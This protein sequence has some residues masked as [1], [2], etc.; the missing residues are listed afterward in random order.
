[1]HH[2]KGG[3]KLYGDSPYT[4]TRCQ[5]KNDKGYRLF[6]GGFGSS[7]LDVFGYNY[8]FPGYRDV[9]IRDE[10]GGLGGLRKF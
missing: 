8:D 4:Y 7:G 9:G 3:D 1:M 6:V 5:E 10:S 2:V